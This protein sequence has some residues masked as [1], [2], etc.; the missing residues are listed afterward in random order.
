MPQKGKRSCGWCYKI[1][2]T[3]NTTHVVYCSKG[4]RD[5]DTLFNYYESDARINRRRHYAELTKGADDGT[6]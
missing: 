4:C 3:T 1:I 2:Q 6:K 5:S